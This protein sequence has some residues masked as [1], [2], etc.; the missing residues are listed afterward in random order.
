[1]PE[2][3]SSPNPNER[4]IFLFLLWEASRDKEKEILEDIAQ[5]FTVLKQYEVAWP[6]ANWVKHLEAFYGHFSQVWIAKARRNGTGN[7]RVVIVEDPHATYDYRDNMRG[8]TERVN[9]NIY[10]AKKR[11]RTLIKSKDKVHSSV[12]LTETRHNLSIL[13]DM[14][15]ADFLKNVK[16][17]G[18]VEYL[19]TTP[20]GEKGWK[21]LS[22]LFYIL[23]ETVPYVVMRNFESLLDPQTANG[24]D[25]IDLMVSDRDLFVSITG[26]TK[27]SS[28]PTHVGHLLQVGDRVV[29]LDL[30]EPGDGY[31]DPAFAKDMIARGHV[32]GGNLRVPSQEDHFFSLLYHALIHKTAVS[33]DYYTFFAANASALGISDYA[34]RFA[35]DGDGYL[36]GLLAEW[37]NRKGYSYC[38]PLSHKV[39]FNTLNI[40]GKPG[41]VALKKS[42]AHLCSVDIGLNRF[43]LHLLTGIDMPNIFRIQIRLG[44]I[45]KIDLCLGDVKEIGI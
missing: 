43:K 24:H 28:K 12:N 38:Q 37:L 16:P 1:M 3:D 39:G 19:I 20:P 45:F 8:M 33:P 4:Q 23:N 6:Q 36:K 34:N 42:H 2:N 44:G 7:F 15:L 21:S 29:K 5:H 31:Y 17:D 18:A 25:D 22:H 11:Y 26:A 41:V 40:A 9:L 30:R 13:L 35:K 14:S 10:D 27:T 32:I